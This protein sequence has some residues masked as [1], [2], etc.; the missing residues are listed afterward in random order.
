[1]KTDLNADLSCSHLSFVQLN[2]ISLNRLEVQS[3]QFVFPSSGKILRP[4]NSPNDSDW[5]ALFMLRN[6]PGADRILAAKGT[7]KLS[8]A[9]QKAI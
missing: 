3:V 6:P 4:V 5:Q 9:G 1:M 7:E 2:D 8:V